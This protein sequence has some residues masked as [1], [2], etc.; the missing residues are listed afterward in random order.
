MALSAVKRGRA[1]KTVESPPQSA[2]TPRLTVRLCEVCK[3]IHP[4]CY[5]KYPHCLYYLPQLY[6]VCLPQSQNDA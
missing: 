4:V 5:T 3:A 2:M 1:S 6:T